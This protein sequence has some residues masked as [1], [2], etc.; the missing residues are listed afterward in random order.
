MDKIV[1]KPSLHQPTSAPN[2]EACFTA[3]AEL[4]L[5]CPLNYPGVVCMACRLVTPLKVGGPVQLY[6][7]EDL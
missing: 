2:T 6:Y 1:L 4:S 7:A 3:T 5:A